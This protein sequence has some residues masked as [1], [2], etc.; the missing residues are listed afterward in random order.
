MFQQMKLYTFAILKYFSEMSAMKSMNTPLL[1]KN[2]GK[3]LLIAVTFFLMTAP[4]SL[5][6]G[7]YTNT[8]TKIGSAEFAA[9]GKDRNMSTVQVFNEAVKYAIQDAENQGE[10]SLAG[11]SSMSNLEVDNIWVKKQANLQVVDVKVLS[12]EFVNNNR[13][14]VKVTVQVTFDYLNIPKFMHE[15]DKTTSGAV[16]RSMA[17][18]GWGQMY[19]KT[20]ITGILYGIMFTFFYYSFIVESNSLQKMP[21]NKPGSGAAWEEQRAEYE[22]RRR[23]VM[24]KYQFPSLV[25]WAF[26]LSEATA[27]HALGHIGLRNLRQ[28]Y[29]LEDYSYVRPTN[30]QGFVIDFYL[31]HLRF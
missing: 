18:P 7:E 27:S 26:A 10:A 29:R 8:I 16:F 1:H 11:G 4:Q 3:F 12:K 9:E 24:F 2:Y 23:S 5:V 22:A 19:N 14:H 13:K 31:F 25:I 28:A 17:F 15:Y 21:G 6:A 20:H 30:E